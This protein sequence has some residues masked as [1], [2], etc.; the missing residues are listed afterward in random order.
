[1]AALRRTIDE[2]LRY[3]FVETLTI[4]LKHADLA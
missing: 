4:H 1:M 2:Q 3:T